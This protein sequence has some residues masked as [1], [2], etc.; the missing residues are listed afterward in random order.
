MLGAKKDTSPPE[1][2]QAWK[3]TFDKARV[4]IISKCLTSPS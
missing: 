1:Y 2:K 3:A 4:N